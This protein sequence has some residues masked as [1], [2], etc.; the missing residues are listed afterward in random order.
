[1]NGRGKEPSKT[2]PYV[3]SL[4]QQPW[5]LDA[6]APGRWD[7]IV[8][9]RGDRVAL[10]FP[11]MIG[12]ENGMTCIDMPPLTQTLGH[13][14]RPVGGK[15]T[16]LLSHQKDLLTE[17][18]EQLPPHD[19]FCQ[20]F[21]YS[22]TN[23]LPFYWNGFSQTTRYTYLIED[24]SDLNRTWEEM[25]TSV[26]QQIRKAERLGVSVTET[27]DIERFLD[28]NELTFRRQG[29]RLPYSRDFVRRL[30]AACTEQ[31]A[32]KIWIASGPDGRP[33]S[34]LYCVFDNQAMYNLMQGGDPE[35]RTSGAN[36]LAMWESIRFA[37]T[38]TK[39]YDFEGS[40]LEN[41]ENYYRDFGAVQKPYFQI[42]RISSRKM[43]IRMHGKEFLRAVLKG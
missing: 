26:R 17:L 3:N 21:H 22:V 2:V 37:A 39:V 27:D 6:V 13:W 20:R 18:I 16:N 23:W 5:W 12:K 42:S 38:V 31:N 43:R 8:I 15:Y 24:L 11:F 7:E 33:H 14:I 4:F 40:M 1:M 35:L 10:R 19:Y 29:M 28:L 30:D 36:T 34:G 41:I 25:D 9:R 32:R